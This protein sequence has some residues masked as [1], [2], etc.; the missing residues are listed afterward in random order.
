MA[1]D[2]YDDRE[3]QIRDCEEDMESKGSQIWLI[4]AAILLGTV[5]KFMGCI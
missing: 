4:V 1:Q 5:L 2:D 3:Q